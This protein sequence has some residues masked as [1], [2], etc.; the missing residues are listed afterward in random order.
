MS[1][2]YF[3]ILMTQGF[4]LPHMKD[5]DE[6]IHFISFPQFKI[7]ITEGTGLPDGTSGR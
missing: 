1:Y 2:V 6:H 7:S 4:S 5:V 3:D